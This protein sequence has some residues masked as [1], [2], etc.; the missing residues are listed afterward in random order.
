M[1]SER[2]FTLVEVLV[3]STVLLVGLLGV[4]GLLDVAGDRTRAAAAREGA[5]NLAREALEL[6]HEVEYTALTATGAA[7]ALRATPALQGPAAG[8]WRVERDR[9]S[10]TLAATACALDDAADGFATTRGAGFCADAMGTPPAGGTVDPNPDDLRRLTVTVSWRADG[11]DRRISRSAIVGNP[12]NAAGAPMIVLAQGARVGETIAFTADT[13]SS[14]TRV[15][16]SVNAVEQAT[17]TPSGG[18]AS[19]T[20]QTT[21]RADATYLVSARA[22]DAQGRSRAPAVVSV[23]LNRAAPTPPARLDGGRTLRVV[24]PS[25]PSAALVDLQWLASP[26]PDVVAY[27]VWRAGHVVCDMRKADTSR[28]PLS[29]TDRSAPDLAGYTYEVEALDSV[30]PLGATPVKGATT[31]HSFAADDDRPAAPANLV[32]TRTATG[33][34]LTWHAASQAGGEPIAFY[35][36]Y[37]GGTGFWDPVAQTGRIDRTGGTETE[38]FDMRAPASATVY[39]VTAVDTRF[40]ESEPSAGATG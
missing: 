29:C 23:R 26:D 19:W 7:A 20:W 16:F 21:G 37:R 36:I 24:D 10:Y 40:G 4:L 25:T 1:R 11:V 33:V 27:R 13:S 2:G 15:V 38:F 9:T 39:H 5:T 17:V 31:A 6:G 18:R 30:P 34:R 22:F 28:D 12:G 32:A 35:R 3:A 8:E 14:A